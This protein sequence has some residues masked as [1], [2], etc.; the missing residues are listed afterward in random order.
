MLSFITSNYLIGT[1]ATPSTSWRDNPTP[2][3]VW[4]SEVMAQQ[5]LVN[6]VIPI[7]ERWMKDFPTIKDLAQ[8]SLQEIM[9]AWKA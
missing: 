4:I 2:Y 5:T 9:V 7:F 3:M 8:A 1:H 6:T